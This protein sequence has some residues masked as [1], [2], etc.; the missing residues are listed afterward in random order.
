MAEAKVVRP[1]EGVTELPVA[2]TIAQG[3]PKGDKWETVIQKGT[4]CG[5]AAFIPVAMARSVAKVEP[6]KEARKLERWQK[7]AQ[8]AA[9]QS[10]RQLVPV[11]SPAVS[12]KHLVSLANDFDVCLFAYEEAAKAGEKSRL[13]HI[14]EGL[15]PG[16]R[17]LVLVGPEGGISPEEAEILTG[18]GF[19]PCGLGPR[20]LRTETAPGYVLAALS[21]AFE[22]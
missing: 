7:I 13:K 19:I 17:L 15:R 9:E 4:E 21:Y 16:M 18:A 11:V 14:I 1:L 12:F 20:I 6:K 5:A 22:L 8:E 3:L 2:V 10:Y